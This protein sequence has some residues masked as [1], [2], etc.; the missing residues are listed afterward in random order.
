MPDPRA[1]ASDRVEQSDEWKRLMTCLDALGPGKGECVRLAYLEGFTRQ[2][3][4][5]RSGQSVA[6]IKAWLHR[7]L[8]QLKDC[9]SS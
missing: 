3:L 5:D 6:T 4:A 8:K 9:L 2:Q 1:L 7:S